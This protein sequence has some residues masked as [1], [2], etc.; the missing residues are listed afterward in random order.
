L[1]N[2][3]NLKITFILTTK[4]EY[5][6]T[7]REIENILETYALE[8]IFELN[9]LSPAD[10]LYFLVEEDFITLPEPRPID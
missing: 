1:L 6:K 10:V 3:L 8:E 5:I 7:I 9:D 2:G 4:V